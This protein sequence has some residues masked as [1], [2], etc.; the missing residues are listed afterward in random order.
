MNN[1]K[2]FTLIELLVVVTIIGLLATMILVSLNAA[3][4][5]AR[6]IRRIAELR[7]VALALEMYYD[8]NPDMA[9]P[10]TDNTESWNAMKSALEA[11]HYISSVPQ[12]LR[13]PTYYY[14][15]YPGSSNQTYVIGVDELENSDNSALNSDVDNDTIIDIIVPSGRC[16]DPEYCIQL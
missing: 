16:D 11:G 3:R 7:Q 15:Y 4:T 1:K 14:F 8:D 12:D 10:G 5:K 2:G 13:Y 6:D 9:Y